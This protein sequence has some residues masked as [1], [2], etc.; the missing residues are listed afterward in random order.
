MVAAA[1]VTAS[2]DHAGHASAGWI[3][4]VA[5][6]IVLVGFIAGAPW[7]GAW[8]VRRRKPGGGGSDEGY[9][10]GGGG[11]GGAPTPP[12]RPPDA[13]PEWWPD[14]ERQFAAYV[15]DRLTRTG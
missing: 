12:N 9:G 4:C 1:V 13:D 14:F 2:L 10:G 8:S 3:T 7:F 6:V 15:E 5:S 11:G